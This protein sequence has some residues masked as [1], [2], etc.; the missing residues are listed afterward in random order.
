MSE[1]TL[2]ELI[3]QRI[4]DLEL[5]FHEHVVRNLEQHEVLRHAVEQRRRDAHRDQDQEA[6]RVAATH[7]ALDK[8]LDGMN[9][10][11]RQ[12]EAER[13]LYVDRDRL[14]AVVKSLEGQIDGVSRNLE[15]QMSGLSERLNQAERLRANLDGRFTML[16]LLLLGASIAL[17]LAVAYLM[18]SVH[19]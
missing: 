1:I 17:N 15:G 9:E 4:A 3:E 10:L 14:D 5:R 2:R 16:G 11:R 19:S 6:A 13:A 12:I 8:R 7:A 18:R